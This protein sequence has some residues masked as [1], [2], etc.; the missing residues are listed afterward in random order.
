MTTLQVLLHIAAH[1]NYDLHSLD[2]STAFLQRSLHEQVSICHPPRSTRSFSSGTKWSGAF[3]CPSTV[4]VSA[5]AA[6]AATAIVALASCATMASLQ[7]LVFDYEDRPVQ[8]DTWLDDLQLYL[9]SD[10]KDSVSLFD[11]AS[12][13]ATAPPATANSATRSQWLTRNA[14]ARLAIRN[15][16]PLAECAHFGQYRTAQ[17]LYDVVVARYSS[18]ATATLGRLLL[19]YL[20]RDICG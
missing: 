7:V 1:H 8:L 12:R 14:A 5:A 15:H 11:I 6:T 13:A 9:L 3:N 4:C 18:P 19:P 2:F 16:L 20:L 10:S 17:A